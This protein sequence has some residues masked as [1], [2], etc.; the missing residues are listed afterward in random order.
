MSSAINPYIA[1]SPVR[2]PSMFFGRESILYTIHKNLVKSTPPRIVVLHGQ[3]RMGKTSTLYQIAFHLPKRYIPMLLDLQGMS[4]DGMGNLCWEVMQIVR[5][6][7]KRSMGVTIPGGDRQRWLADP[8]HEITAFF[9]AIQRVVGDQHLV[10]MFDET[11]LIADK[12][13]AGALEAQVFTCF[14]NLMAEFAFLDFVFSMGS[15]LVLMKK[16]LASLS[17][18]ATYHEIGLLEPNVARALIVTP[19]QGTLTY[20]SR[21]VEQIL[22]LTAGQPYYTQLVCHALFSRMQAANRNTIVTADVKAVCPQVVEA[23]I[24]QLHYLWQQ[25]S[26]LGQRI[27]LALI[28]AGKQAGRG[29]SIDQIYQSLA[30]QEGAITISIEKVAKGLQRLIARYIVT[31][32]SP[33]WFRMDLFRHWI[34]RNRRI[35]NVSFYEDP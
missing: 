7:I 2:N 18:R 3:R 8:T 29:V 28:R 25:T 5:R 33:Y 22:E 15:K 11:M 21:S 34:L 1:G 26:P 30:E 6:A 12:I 24:A 17:R 9:A 31:A 35:E 4:L 10:L 14:S 19:V 32:D 20:E 27:L 13:Q 23:A 16:E